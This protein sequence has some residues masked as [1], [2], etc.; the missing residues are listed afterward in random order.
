MEDQHE[1]L[2]TMVAKMT[3][4]NSYW[5]YLFSRVR[6]I[7]TENIPSIM[8]V[9]PEKDGTISLLFHPG[10]MSKTSDDVIKKIVE[11]EGMHILQK[12]LPRL[13]RILANEVSEEQKF[14]KLKIWNIAADC[15]VNPVINMPKVLTIAE[16]PW[17]GCFPD[18][19]GLKNNKS[20][21]YYFNKLMEQVKVEIIKVGTDDGFGSEFDPI[22]DH[23]SWGNVVKDVADVSA[24]SRKIDSY[25]HEI[26]KDSLKSFQRKRG[27]MPGYISELIDRALAPPKVPYYQ[28]IRKL[29][30][31]SRLS[32]FKRAF[33]KV[34]RKRT[35]VFTIGDE[36]NVPG[37]SPFPGRT[38]DFS[39][40]IV[41]LIDTS[42]SMSP[43]DIKEGL[44]GVKNI[45]ESDR[46]T[47]TI[48]IEND[49]QV[50]K[51]YEVKR[52]RDIDF[53][54]SGRG[55]TILQ[56]GLERAWELK[57]DVC[58]TFT[59]G[60]CDDINSIPRKW[61][62]RKIIWVIQKDGTIENVNRT[63]YIVRI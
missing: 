1:R 18:L 40:N 42:G 32:K 51:E 5:G 14:F 52:I 50:Q 48:I 28:I 22:D 27:M 26:I 20:T 39:F 31:G 24:L 33:A 55:G 62:P 8:G 16:K 61:L 19:Y 45:I 36:K 23:S 37:I 53:R 38:R 35:Y 47:K 41:V 2:K 7:A 30:K 4:K 12:H 10:L 44:S 6:R 21:E 15:A 9:A 60:H 58:L 63:G 34:N 56:P 25:V 46:H 59:D 13:L 29:V 57:P 11:H 49:T 43:D 17:Q 3:L 54:I